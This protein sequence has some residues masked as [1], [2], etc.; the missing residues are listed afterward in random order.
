[1]IKILMLPYR[2]MANASYNISNISSDRASSFINTF[3]ANN[4]N[5]TSVPD[6]GTALWQIVNVYP[7]FVGPIAWFVLFAIPFMMMWM[8]HAD[9]VPAGALGFFMGIYITGFVGGA[10]FGIG[11]LLCMVSFASIVWSLW[12]RRL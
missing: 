12:L 2:A 1:M 4:A 7:D 9:L 8:G 11:I 10:Y 6:W 3:G 5:F